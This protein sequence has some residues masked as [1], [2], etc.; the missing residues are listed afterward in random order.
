MNANLLAKLIECDNW[1]KLVTR[2]EIANTL[3]QLQAENEA[4][5]KDVI[6]WQSLASDKNDEV[7]ELERQK[8]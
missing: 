6:E 1:Y 3:R 7:I 5:K 4:L 8:K 2:E